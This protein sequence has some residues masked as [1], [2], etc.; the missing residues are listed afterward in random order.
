M[1]LG[2]DEPRKHCIR[3]L[4]MCS[5]LFATGVWGRPARADVAWRRGAMDPV[6]A[7]ARQ[8]RRIV[9]VDFGADWC[10][11]CQTMD[12]LV[13]SRAD[14]GAAVSQGYVALRIDADARDGS[15]LMRRYHVG[16]L[17]TVLAV[18]ADGTEI[19]RLTG[20]S[21]AATVLAALAAWRHGQGTL[22]VLAARVEQR[23]DNLAM[24]LDVGT[25]Y[26]DR[27][28][29]ALALRHLQRV[30]AADPHNA[31]GYR[32][33]ALLAL[34][35]RLYLRAMHD[36]AQAV[37]LLQD[38]VR[39][40]P[41]S[42]PG[43]QAHV[44]LAMALHRT[45]QDDVARAVIDAYLASATDGTL[46]AR[47]SNVADLVLPERWDLPRTEQ[48]VRS[49]S[50]RAPRVHTLIDTLAELV[51]AQGRINDA[52]QLEQRAI[53]ADPRNEHYRRQLERFQTAAAH[54]GSSSPPPVEPPARPGAAPSA[55]NPGHG[56]AGT[57]HHAAPLRHRATTTG[58]HP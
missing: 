36:P 24:Q 11:P 44:P 12:A 57:V 8:T 9:V 22:G 51:F 48:L 43:A 35:D 29:V 15:A 2:F 54:A 16:A 7:E 42:E 6:L 34:G 26:A 30:L 27:G 19:D 45:H 53:T 23:P 14:V 25:R 52:V 37:P 10:D 38:L 47:A 41:N 40:Y 4:A 56:T 20:D 18:R 1:R 3:L 32:S 28:E 21:D 5:F 46:G 13:W 17:P 50:A 49:A 33:R 55:T 58:T 39:Q 31:Q